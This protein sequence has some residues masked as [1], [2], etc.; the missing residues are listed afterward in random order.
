MKF[1]MQRK[2]NATKCLK[3]KNEV[4]KNTPSSYITA[5]VLLTVHKRCY[6]YHGDI[7][8]VAISYSCVMGEVTIHRSSQSLIL[9]SSFASWRGYP[10]HK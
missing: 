4:T 6:P 5:F 2:T 9:A 3:S 7:L 8:G 10:F 1:L